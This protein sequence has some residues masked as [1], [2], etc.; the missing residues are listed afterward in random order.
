M[1]AMKDKIPGV[2][3]LL[4]GFSTGWVGQK[5]QIV[6]TVDFRSKDDFDAYIAHPYHADY[7]NKTGEKYFDSS[8]FV[9]AQFEFTERSN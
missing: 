9:I 8:S 4:V 1:E 2:V 3:D 6:M 7:I 5:N